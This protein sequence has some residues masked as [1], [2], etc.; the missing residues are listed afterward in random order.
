M[1]Y[2]LNE[3]MPDT[4]SWVYV[5]GGRVYWWERLLEDSWFENEVYCRWDKFRKDKI[6]SANIELMIDTTVAYLGAAVDRN[7]D[8]YPILGTYVW[9]NSYYPDTYEEEIAFLK[10][11]TM[12]RLDWMDSQ[13]ANRCV[14]TAN[15]E[16]I[17][18]P[19]RTLKV[20][21]NPSDFSNLSF[22]L[23]TESG[24][25][26]LFIEVMDMNGVLIEKISEKAIPGGMSKYTMSDR[27]NLP[28]GI[29]VYKVYSGSELIHVG[30][31]IKNR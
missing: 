8:L 7:Y 19:N 28:T 31:L 11:W 16:V 30:K 9:P 26:E 3:N 1:D 17:A 25:D 15:A 22:E 20:H 27:S 4:H 12:E 10:S 29:Y 13:W 14:R 18:H 5:N 2:G 24:M 21:P 6:S 23:Y